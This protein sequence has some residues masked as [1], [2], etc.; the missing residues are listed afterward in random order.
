[1][2]YRD[3]FR[4]RPYGEYGDND[5]D[6]LELAARLRRSPAGLGHKTGN[7]RVA[8]EQMI[9]IV[10]ISRENTNLDDA[11]NRNGIQE[12]KGFDQLKRILLSVITEFE[13]DRQYIGRK[14]AA[15]KKKQDELQNQLDRM[16]EKAEESR[17]WQ[18]E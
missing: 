6:W 4:V 15:Y 13:R 7:W 16:R 11:A 14:L 10:D 17:K 3:H 12:G 18:E 1:K 5:F 2:L 8:P 9:G